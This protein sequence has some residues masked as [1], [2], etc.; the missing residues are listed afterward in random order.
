MRWAEREN[1]RRRHVDNGQR[2]KAAKTIKE[3]L[4]KFISLFGFAGLYAMALMLELHPLAVSQDLVTATPNLKYRVLYAFPG[5]EAPEGA[6][7]A[8]GVITDGSGN[9]YGTTIDGGHGAYDGCPCPRELEC[10]RWHSL[11]RAGLSTTT[12]TG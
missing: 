10:W 6:V 2:T 9:V 11:P 8:A 5:Q 7:P 4:M 1:G 3:S 12:R